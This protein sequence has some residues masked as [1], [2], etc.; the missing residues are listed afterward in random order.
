MFETRTQ[1]NRFLPGTDLNGLAATYARTIGKERPKPPFGEIFNPSSFRVPLSR[2]EYLRRD[3]DSCLNDLGIK[4]KRPGANALFTQD[5]EGVALTYQS[6]P[7]QAVFDLGIETLPSDRGLVSSRLTFL[8]MEQFMLIEIGIN[9]DILNPKL[10]Q[11]LA[12]EVIEDARRTGIGVVAL[13]STTST[14]GK[15]LQRMGM[16]VACALEEDPKQRSLFILKPPSEN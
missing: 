1:I 13:A 15:Q 3:G 16:V 10:E 5:P 7:G 2:D 11:D 12:E 9:P 6:D 14:L 8:G 4:L